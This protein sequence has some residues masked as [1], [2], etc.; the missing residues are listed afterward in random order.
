M[1][2]D[3]SYTTYIDS[4]HKDAIEICDTFNNECM[5]YVAHLNQDKRDVDLIKQKMTILNL[6]VLYATQ[7]QTTLDLSQNLT[8][9]AKIVE[10]IKQLDALWPIFKLYI[11]NMLGADARNTLIRCRDDAW[12]RF[13]KNIAVLFY[14]LIYNKLEAHEKFYGAQRTYGYNFFNQR[15]YES[16]L[17]KF[18][19]R[20]RS[21]ADTQDQESQLSYQLR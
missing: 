8:G 4:L 17:L 2:Y 18:V 6:G 10:Q 12:T 7:M 13:I 15:L 5:R 3:A 19:E 1:Q 9:D 20:F 11:A 14:R 16:Q 21:F